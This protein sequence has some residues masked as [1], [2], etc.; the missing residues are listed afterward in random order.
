MK[1]WF[2]LPV[3]VVLWVI[4]TSDAKS[5]GEILLLQDIWRKENKKILF[6]RPLRGWV[7]KNE[8]VIQGVRRILREHIVAQ[9]T[10]INFLGKKEKGIDGIGRISE[11]H[12]LI[13]IQYPF[14]IIS[15]SEIRL[16]SSADLPKIKKVSFK[17]LDQIL[18]FE[19]DYNILIKLLTSSF[20]FFKIAIFV[21]A[22]NF[23]IYFY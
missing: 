15:K 12:Y 3:K 19:E 23:F 9:R 8:R 18:L 13:K 21:W 4:T 1:R 11:C 17:N 14:E 16:V 20:L 5:S 10:E 6:Y 2:G 22:L 7:R